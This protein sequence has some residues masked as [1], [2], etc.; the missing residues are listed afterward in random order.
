M[1]MKFIRIKTQ[2]IAN[3]P[4]YCVLLFLVFVLGILSDAVYS[5]TQANV[6]SAHTVG[7]RAANMSCKCLLGSWIAAGL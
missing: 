6:C 5:P 3:N 2:G 7:R 4:I 1:L